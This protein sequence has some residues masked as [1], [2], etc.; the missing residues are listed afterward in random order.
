[1]QNTL[2]DNS[3]QFRLVDYLNDLVNDT[4]CNE[5]CIATGYW[6]LKGTKLLY[7]AL[8]PFFERGG[9]MRLLIG[10]EP[11]VRTYQLQ[12]DI[13]KEEK[14]PDFYIQRDI[15]QLTEEYAPVARM[16]LRYSNIEEQDNSQIQIR[17]YGQKG[18]E[19]KFLHAKCYIFLGEKQ[20]YGILG[21]SNFTERGLQDNAELNHLEV[22]PN[23]VTGSLSQYNPYK[24]HLVWFDDMWNDK[25]CEEWTGK[26]IKDILQKAPVAKVPV[27]KPEPQSNKLTPYETYIR[28]LQD[29]FGALADTDVKSVLKN[30]LPTEYN[31]YDY[32]IDA[33]ALCYEIM[34]QH[35]GFMLGDVVGLGK[36]VVGVLLI[37][38]YLEFAESEGRDRKVLII[39]PPAIK[40]AWEQ[41]IE[42]FDELRDDKI[43]PCIQYITTG[44]I[45]KLVD[46]SDDDDDD[47]VSFDG[48]LKKDHYGLIIIDES[49]N[50]R[51]NETIMYRSLDEL[52]DTIGRETG[53][54]PYI[55]LLSATPQNNTPEDLQNQI[56]LFQR[57]PRN[58]TFPGVEARNLESFFADK[59]DRYNKIVHYHPTSE[60]EKQANQA[61]LIQLS[62]EINNK[63]LTEILVRR[64][65]SDVRDGYHAD[66]HFP[67]VIGPRN[68]DYN[69]SPRLAQLF[70]DTMECIAPNE[71]Q[72]LHIGDN[73]ISYM[74]YR[75]IEYL[76]DD[77]VRNRYKGRGGMTPEKTSSHLAKIMQILL[78]KRLESSFSAFRRSLIN[79]QRYTQNMITMWENDTIF[80]CPQID[81]NKEL[82]LEEKRKKD[83]SYTIERCFDD[84]RAKI[85]YLTENGKNNKQQNAEYHRSDFQDTYYQYLLEDIALINNLVDRWMQE[86]QD[87]KLHKF[88]RSIDS[89]FDPQENRPQKLVIFSEAI[90]TVK[91]LEDVVTSA[92]YTA[93]CITAANRKEKEQIIRE[94]FDANYKGEWK[95][96]YQVIITTEVLA[97]GVNLHRANTI[98]NYD[99]PWNSTRLIQR[100][101]R[102]NRIGS[103]EK[104]VYVYNF[105]PSAEGDNEINLVNR[106][107][108]KLQSFHALF[109]EDNK[110]FSQEE[111]LSKTD[112]KKMV[113]G[114]QTPFTRHIVALQRY[115][116]EHPERFEY[117]CNVE[118]PM[119]TA[120]H[121]DEQYVYC[122]LK[123]DT[124]ISG[125]MYV[126]VNAEGKGDMISSLELFDALAC[127]PATPAA[128]ALPLETFSESA[129]NTYLAH[130]DAL[131]QT[132]ATGKHIFDD[133]LHVIRK[134]ITDERLTSESRNRFNL[135]S[136]HIENRN[137]SVA[138]IVLAISREIGDPQQSLF[139][140][141]PEEINTIIESKL[142][143]LR[144]INMAQHGK[145]YIF[146]AACKVE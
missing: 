51:N 76:S 40:S 83:S 137:K 71:K 80:I 122:V 107:F 77:E 84:I 5:I 82:N 99:T 66:L 135:A 7:D 42:A 118:A 145:P 138:N 85:E 38:Y 87:P 114:E 53:Y 144:E 46:D 58:C 35:G 111:Q 11:T 41:T 47:A 73:Y 19:K 136:I 55:G 109:G 4:K 10:E 123:T 94:N 142:R 106:A 97:E 104:N 98:L 139:P 88:I 131:Q 30:Y 21:S 95:D 56:Y 92:G 22:N 128:E 39:V 116:Q 14:F 61:G 28:V 1:M 89:L 25:S 54:F 29:R 146:V 13:P 68:L 90:D 49:H 52:I 36:T 20:A 78:V 67:D 74:R 120:V 108:T 110:V 50:F 112:Y 126:R 102:V 113:D 79:L 81:V 9:K 59:K 86:R 45:D 117:I 43:Q 129:S 64:T 69:L 121:A 27:E 31:A 115:K 65:R 70:A 24:T 57:T 63:V 32:Q 12:T 26:F 100:I 127:D 119:V 134:W 96:D 17:V 8:L 133:A 60:T 140:I 48:S 75:A 3:E 103:A 2:I 44:S 91:E 23:S 34:H 6:D 62:K 33:A 105:Y 125:S 130:I 16:L 101:G 93:L 72:K 15:N 132:S 143:N 18:A 124:N 141:T 37:K